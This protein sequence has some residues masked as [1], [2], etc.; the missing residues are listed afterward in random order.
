MKFLLILALSFLAFTGFSQTTKF[1]ISGSVKDAGKGEELINA[2]VKVKGQNL[3]AFS[4]E[5]GFYSLTLPQGKYTLVITAMG[6][7]SREQEIDLN[8]NLNLDFQLDAEGKV[9]NIEEVKI[10]GTKQDNN[11]KDPVMGVER[12]DPKEIAKI[13]VLL[14]EKD[15][16]KTMQLLPGVKSAGEGN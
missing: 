5:Y 4:N 6:F 16:I 7:V 2:T 13:P 9:Q 14:G 10:T 11:V 3:G 15:I 12:L 8:Q 1:T